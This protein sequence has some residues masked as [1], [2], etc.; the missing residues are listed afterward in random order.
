MSNPTAVASLVVLGP[1]HKAVEVIALLDQGRTDLDAIRS[2]AMTFVVDM[3][4]HAEATALVSKLPLGDFIAIN[5]KQVEFASNRKA[6]VSQGGLRVTFSEAGRVV[7]N[8][9]KINSSAEG[10]GGA[11]LSLFPAQASTLID[12]L[13]MFLQAMLD[14]AETLVPAGEMETKLNPAYDEARKAGKSDAAIKALGI[15]KLVKVPHARAGKT[16]MQWDGCDKS[17]TVGK[18]RSALEALRTMKPVDVLK[19]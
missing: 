13:P 5:A 9:L 4:N 17:A 8:G 10:K 12:G 6:T 19:A 15:A 14:N 18:I 1:E 2:W 11:P 7:L 3:A 16:A